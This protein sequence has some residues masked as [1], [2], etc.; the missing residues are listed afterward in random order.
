MYV[1][2]FVW[3]IVAYYCVCMCES[4]LVHVYVKVHAL[5]VVFTGC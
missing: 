3:V 1:C 5:C 4:Y 2:V